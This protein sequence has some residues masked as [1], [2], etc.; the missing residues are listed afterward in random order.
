MQ[1]ATQHSSSLMAHNELQSILLDLKTMQEN[2]EQYN[3]STNN[4]L[5]G[6]MQRLFL[7]EIQRFKKTFM[8]IQKRRDRDQ[9]KEDK[10]LSEF[11]IFRD[12]VASLMPLRALYL[13]TLQI[14]QQ[15]GVVGGAPPTPIP[16]ISQQYPQPPRPRPAP[17]KYFNDDIKPKSKTKTSVEDIEK[18]YNS[19]VG[20]GGAGVSGGGGSSVK[21]S[22][23][24]NDD[25]NIGIMKHTHQS[26][27]QT[28]SKQQQQDDDRRFDIKTPKGNNKKKNKK[29]HYSPSPIKNHELEHE[30]DKHHAV[31]EQGQ[32]VNQ[33]QNL[34]D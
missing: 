20:I 28:Q 25:F 14:P 18:L 30:H 15:Y 2:V 4:K 9:V 23:N 21:K 26:Q 24:S 16:T 34:F 32:D 1:V 11:Y 8:E 12:I 19:V 33:Q 6:S 27:S 17:L 29:Q 7:G 31:N 5:I 10:L 3:I 22:S 13:Q